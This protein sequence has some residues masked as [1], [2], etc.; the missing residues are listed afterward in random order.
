MTSRV[1]ALDWLAAACRLSLHEKGKKRA[2]LVKLLIPDSFVDSAVRHLV[3]VI[4]AKGG[5]MRPSTNGAVPIP[6]ISVAKAGAVGWTS[7]VR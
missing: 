5:R 2:S 7:G 4:Q 3:A 1:L 6:E